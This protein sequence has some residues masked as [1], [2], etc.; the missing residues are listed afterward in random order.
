LPGPARVSTSPP[1]TGRAPTHAGPP[2]PPARPAAQWADE[3]GGGAARAL[4]DLQHS[5]D[6]LAASGG[7][8][9][10]AA[11]AVLARLDSA[12]AALRAANARFARDF[13]AAPPPAAPAAAG[14]AASALA[15]D[16]L[17]SFMEQMEEAERRQL[18]AD[19]DK[20]ARAGRAAAEQAARSAAA[21]A[22]A[23]AERALAAAAAARRG[24]A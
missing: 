15:E 6:A 9:T 16:H 14:G 3:L 10:G 22:A 1:F 5:V 23:E 12:C 17:R 24:G 13:G 8:S 2:P 4:E 7:A 18:E 11:D 20:A 21:A 19:A